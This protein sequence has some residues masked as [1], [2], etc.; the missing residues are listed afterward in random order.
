M[1]G[2][3]L[4]LPLQTGYPKSN[5]LH[6]CCCIIMY[7]SRPKQSILKMPLSYHKFTKVNAN[8]SENLMN[9]REVTCYRQAFPPES[10]STTG[11]FMSLNFTGISF[12]KWFSKLKRITVKSMNGPQYVIAVLESLDFHMDTVFCF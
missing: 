12:G 8:R 11:C 1:V 9:C 7:C 4:S 2:T 5:L 3:G 10:N 6:G